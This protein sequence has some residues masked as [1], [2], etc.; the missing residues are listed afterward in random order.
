MKNNNNYYGYSDWSQGTMNL[1]S[2]SHGY[3]DTIYTKVYN[4]GLNWDL[5]R[6][7]SIDAITQ[8]LIQATAQYTNGLALYARSG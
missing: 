6:D 7:T 8:N 5:T 2:Y 4:K 1:A 3:V